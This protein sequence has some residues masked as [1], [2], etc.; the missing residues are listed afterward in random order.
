MYSTVLLDTRVRNGY[1]INTNNG[2]NNIKAQRKNGS[3]NFSKSL[4]LFD[5]KI[6]HQLQGTYMSWTT[7]NISNYRKMPLLL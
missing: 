5:H 1:R 7:R 2:N 4:F 3:K 6:E